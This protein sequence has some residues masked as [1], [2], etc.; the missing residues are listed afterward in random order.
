M[1]QQA[2]QDLINECKLVV[3]KETINGRAPMM[4]SNIQG[5]ELADFCLKFLDLIDH[6]TLGRIILTEMQ[7]NAVEI[8]GP[9]IRLYKGEPGQFFGLF[10]TIMTEAI[11]AHAHD[12]YSAYVE[13]EEIA[14]D[15]AP[16]DCKSELVKEYGSN[17]S[18][19]GV[20]K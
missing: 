10:G 16:D 9:A 11:L 4:H 17:V 15:Y 7:E 1:K 19:A 3:T 13:P 20:T 18:F 2:I 6:E 12:E 8:V 14:P 5:R